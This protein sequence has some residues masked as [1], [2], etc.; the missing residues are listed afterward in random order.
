VI[1]KTPEAVSEVLFQ[2]GGATEVV[3]YVSSKNYLETTCVG[4]KVV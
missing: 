3:S 4:L 2:I 1:L